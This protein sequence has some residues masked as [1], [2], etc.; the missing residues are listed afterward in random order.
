MLLLNKLS[1]TFVLMIIFGFFMEKSQAQT[2]DVDQSSG[3]SITAAF[4]YVIFGGETYPNTTIYATN[5]TEADDKASRKFRGLEFCHRGPCISEGQLAPQE[6]N[7]DFE[8]PKN[9]DD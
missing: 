2:Q 8:T 6:E 5:R 7:C 9:N 4:C 3:D 1:Y